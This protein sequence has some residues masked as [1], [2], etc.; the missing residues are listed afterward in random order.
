MIWKILHG[1][2]VGGL[3]GFWITHTPLRDNPILAGVVL[4]GFMVGVALSP[5][6]TAWLTKRF[7]RPKETTNSEPPLATYLVLHQLVAG[8]NEIHTMVNQEEMS[9]N[10]RRRLVASILHTADKVN[11]VANLGEPD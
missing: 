3:F 11:A 8:M 1:S 9:D 4:C 2:L 5:L 6:A 7:T 10:V